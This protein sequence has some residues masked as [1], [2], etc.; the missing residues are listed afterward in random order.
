MTG[1]SVPIGINGECFAPA[2]ILDTTRTPGQPLPVSL[3]GKPAERSIERDYLNETRDSLPLEVL[4]LLKGIKSPQTDWFDQG[5]LLAPYIEAMRTNYPGVSQ[6]DLE[7]YFRELAKTEDGFGIPDILTFNGLT[8][9]IALQLPVRGRHEYYEI[10]PGSENGERDGRTKL[11]VIPKPHRKFKMDY[12]PGTTYPREVVKHVRP[13]MLSAFVHIV[14]V[15]MRQYGIRTVRV[16]LRVTR[17]APGLLLYKLCIDLALEGESKHRVA[18]TKALAKT[19]YAAYVV[20]HN[21]ERFRPKVIEELK[22]QIGDFNL[23]R[24]ACKFDLPQPLQKHK[25]A[26]EAAIVGRGLGL[27]GETYMLCADEE[28]YRVVLQPPTPDYIGQLWSAILQSAEFKV[29]SGGLPP[30]IIWQGIKPYVLPKGETGRILQVLFPLLKDLANRALDWMIQH[31][32][33]T[34]ALIAVP[35]VLTAGATLLLAPA[36]AAAEVS[37][38]GAAAAA[39]SVTIES[40]ATGG[41][42]LGVMAAEEAL[43]A[44][45]STAR[46]A[47]VLMEAAQLSGALSNA[48]GA[49]AAA[50]DI[51]WIASGL[52]AMASSRVVKEGMGI[53]VGL[54]LLLGG[55]RTAAAATLR[56]VALPTPPPPQSPTPGRPT[57]PAPSLA[58]VYTLMVNTSTVYAQASGAPPTPA[59]QAVVQALSGLHMVRVPP[60]WWPPRKF[61]VGQEVNLAEL[62]D[63]TGLRIPGAPAIMSRYAGIVRL[64]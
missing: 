52:R 48:G 58:A 29:L 5:G 19:V 21:E 55:S 14:K 3:I 42:L 36:L 60:S 7:A 20:V 4:R 62:A 8:G 43:L 41:S 34:L 22:K 35:M 47:S 23:P 37:F 26:F 63:I 30:E 25:P 31:P 59:D 64:S 6:S 1:S 46:A 45:T 17:A 61:T 40:T 16:Y 44:T 51:A 27:P 56:N 24:V 53:A 12:K 50:N 32:Y 9:I 10:K 39:A 49:G 28:F 57:P 15:L 11:R 18:L 54:P 38:A 33:Q 13:I 2:E